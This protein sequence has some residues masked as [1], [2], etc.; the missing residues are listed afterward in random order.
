MANYYPRW[1]R[2]ALVPT[3]AAVV[4][5]GAFI[6]TPWAPVRGL[7]V[8]AVAWLL[9]R[10]FLRLTITSSTIR[11]R[12]PSTARRATLELASVVDVASARFAIGAFPGWVFS[13]SHG[14]KVFINEGAFANAA[15]RAVIE[16]AKKGSQ[17]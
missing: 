13:D 11:G 14:K 12:D 16:N 3:L 7:I 4:F 1:H 9:W 15:V 6:R 2:V 17:P 10:R 5:G 8:F